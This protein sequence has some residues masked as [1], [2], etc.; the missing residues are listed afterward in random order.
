MSL[1]KIMVEGMLATPT[2]PYNLFAPHS[3]PN[4]P[5]RTPGNPSSLNLATV[6]LPLV[7]DLESIEDSKNEDYKGKIL[8]KI[9]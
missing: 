9:T 1:A 6:T 4:Y 7:F 5:S 3:W 8:Q 2:P